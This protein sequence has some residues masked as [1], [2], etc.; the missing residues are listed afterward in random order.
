MKRTRTVAALLSAALLT[1]TL[2]A[3]GGK[4]NTDTDAGTDADAAQ[5][6]G[7]AVQVQRVT[8]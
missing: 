4:T 1:M 6:F 2:S 8:A 7:T 5:T 3:C